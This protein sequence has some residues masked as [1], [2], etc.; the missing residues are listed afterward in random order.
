MSA[1]TTHEI[2][3]D[4]HEIQV[5]PLKIP[6]VLL[7]TAHILSV[8][9]FNAGPSYVGYEPADYVTQNEDLNIF[10]VNQYFAGNETIID[11]N[12]QIKQQIPLILIDIL[13][14]LHKKS[15]L[16]EDQIKYGS[17]QAKKLRDLIL[18]QIA[19]FD[20]TQASH[21]KTPVGAPAGGKKNKSKTSKK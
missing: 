12:K 11:G 16:S 8:R 6:D 4:S 17:S 1:Q 9:N 18:P 10:A 21:P 14:H 7:K 15:R 20:A 2:P 19:P 3:E 13:E 5:D